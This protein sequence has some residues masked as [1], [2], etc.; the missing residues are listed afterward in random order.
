[1]RKESDFFRGKRPWSKIKDQ[2]IKDYLIP[3]LNKVSK[4][5]K[6]IVVV[7][8]F[9]GPGR[10]DDGSEG[11]PLVIC[12]TAEKIVPDKYLAIFMNSDNVSYEKLN[13]NI[14]KYMDKN[15]AKNIFGQAKDLL[16]NLGDIIGD[17]TLLV[18][19]D[20]SV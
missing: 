16:S 3:Y 11:S 14:K 20:P 15:S 8:A 2:I 19:L 12:E 7:D 4:L 13:K 9:A 1:M 10:F 18:Y 6:T 5:N 17:S